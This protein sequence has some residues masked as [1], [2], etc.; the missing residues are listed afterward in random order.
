VGT[1][2]AKNLWTKKKLL[3]KKKD[4]SISRLKDH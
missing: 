1:G 2:N 3:K 4:Y